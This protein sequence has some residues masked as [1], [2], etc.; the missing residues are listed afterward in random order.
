MLTY[1]S[2]SEILRVIDSLQ[3]TAYKKV[4]TPANWQVGTWYTHKEDWVLAVVGGVRGLQHVTI[5]SNYS[6]HS[7][8]D[9]LS[10]I[11][12]IVHAGLCS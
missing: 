7:S 5:E 2:C 4:A 9:G 1:V 3:L 12:C 10:Y 8:V 11:I 6:N